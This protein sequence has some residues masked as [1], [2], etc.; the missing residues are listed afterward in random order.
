MGFGLALATG[1]GAAAGCSAESESDDEETEDELVI[2]SLEDA[3]IRVPAAGTTLVELGQPS[4]MAALEGRGLHLAAHFG[5]NESLANDRLVQRSRLMRFIADDVAADLDAQRTRD[6]KVG[7]QV[8]HGVT[9]ILDKGWLTA[10]Y[11]RFELTA[12]VNRLDRLAVSGSSSCGEVRF[13][14]R[15]AYSRPSASAASVS[16][17]RLPLVLNVVYDVPRTAGIDE[18]V[19]TAK[20]WTVPPAAVD[21]D[22]YVAYLA[23]EVLALPRLRLRQVEL[24]AQVLRVPSESKTD[25]GG[26][27]E[28]AL[29]VYGL[30]GEAPRHL[31]LE[32]TPDVTRIVADPALKDELAAYLAAHVDEIDLG[33]LK[34]PEK[35]LATKVSAFS[36]FGSARMVNKPFSRLFYDAGKKSAPSLAVDLSR[37]TYLKS[38]PGLLA[39]LDDMTCNGCHQGGRS[40]A[41]FHSLGEDSVARSHPLNVMRVSRSPHLLDELARRTAF[42]RRLAEGV[43]PSP[44]RPVSFAPSVGLAKRGAP[45]SMPSSTSAFAQPIACESGLVCTSI[46]QNPQ[47]P[48]ELGQCLP[49]LR[50]DGKTYSTEFAGLPCARG[51]I[52]DDAADPRRD[53]IST[54]NFACPAPSG[55]GAGAGY[56]CRPAAIGVPGGLCTSLCASGNV[57]RD[58]AH[59]VCGYAGGKE[60]DECANRND[61]SK[62]LVGA[63]QSGL[64][65]ACDETTPCREDWICQR[66]IKARSSPPEAPAD[67][68]G[69]CVPTYFLFQVRAD[70]HPNPSATAR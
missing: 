18:C 19:R 46:A 62:C 22:K 32:N 59:E 13:L 17:S 45:C 7:T 14:Y 50:S 54:T 51:E 44:M 58:G 9:R 29:R 26:V 4:L 23:N 15:L 68:R 33:T 37:A 30:D 1:V 10:S 2:S 21:A 42:V 24:N 52:R 43:E 12:V 40:V 20:A 3:P 6:P 55:G 61:F 41:G 36:T 66:F 39:R 64:R 60:F 38:L 70:G 31:P 25:M 35:F 48:V 5:S 34:L 28:Y 65:E 53:A 8:A 27:A 49:P 11:A 47:V 56:T 63:I 16:Y 57:A 67:G 69:Y